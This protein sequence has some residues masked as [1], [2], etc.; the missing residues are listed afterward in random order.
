MDVSI[1]VV[2][3]NTRDLLQNCLDSIY[4]EVGNVDFEV[5]V[6]DNTSTDGSTDMVRTLFPK[7]VLIANRIN[8]GYAAALNQG[9][10]IAQGRYFLALNSDTIICDAA[11]EKTLE[12]ADQH[13]EAA[14]VGCQVYKNSE[15]VQMT[16]SRFPS[17]LNLFLE[18]LALRKIFKKNHFVGRHGI[19]GWLRDSER[20]VDV[21]SGVFMLVRREA[22]EQ[23]GLMDE[24]YF[25]LFEETD[26]CYRFAK[27]GW[28]MMFWPGARIIHVHG[29]RQSRNKANVK[30]MVQ[31]YK[32]SLIFFKKHYSLAEY[33][34]ARFLL[35]VV[36]SVKCVAWG[37]LK[38][39]KELTHNDATYETTRMR[40]FWLSLRFCLTGCEPTTEG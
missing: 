19:R 29:G 4:K 2:N 38:L 37:F 33:L 25:L 30:M 6:V 32:S 11:V 36:C 16:C 27:A 13:P 34:L 28:K 15:D 17:V 5:I 24:A 18:A 20:Q 26:W 3:W 14:V 21:V 8:K 7:A 23:V 40:G 1:I 31:F 22:V 39:S 9:M 12:Y 10:R 35:A